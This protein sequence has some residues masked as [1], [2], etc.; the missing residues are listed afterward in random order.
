M[1]RS[2]ASA[3]AKQAARAAAVRELFRQLISA[4]LAAAPPDAP[5]TQRQRDAAQ[6]PAKAS[7]SG[8]HT[9]QVDDDPPHL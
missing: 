5:E 9:E 6:S 7:L 4:A 8:A 2:N 1:L 3:A